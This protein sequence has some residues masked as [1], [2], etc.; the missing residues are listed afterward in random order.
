MRTEL[1]DV[2]QAGIQDLLVELVRVDDRYDH[3]IDLSQST[4]L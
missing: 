1:I 3:T 2:V 4:R